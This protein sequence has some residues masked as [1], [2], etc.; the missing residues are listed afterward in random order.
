M[1]GTYDVATGRIRG[2]DAE[3]L[4]KDVDPGETLITGIDD[5]GAVVGIQMS[6]PGGPIYQSF[7]TASD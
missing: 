4:S 1:L 7:A 6:L 2:F 5:T 3:A